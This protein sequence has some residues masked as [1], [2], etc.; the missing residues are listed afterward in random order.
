MEIGMLLVCVY[1]E[2]LRNIITSKHYVKKLL[3]MNKKDN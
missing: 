2:Q 1:K 3:I